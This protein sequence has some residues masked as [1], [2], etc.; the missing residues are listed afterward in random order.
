MCVFKKEKENQWLESRG[1]GDSVGERL[2]PGPGESCRAGQECL[3]FIPS[4]WETSR[5]F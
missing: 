3:D 2:G 5:Q 4:V 1:L